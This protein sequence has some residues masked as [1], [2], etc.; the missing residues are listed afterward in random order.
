MKIQQWLHTVQSDTELLR[1]PRH[2]EQSEATPRCCAVVPELPSQPGQCRELGED[3]EGSA[4]LSPAE[5][6]LNVTSVR[7]RD[8]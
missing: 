4:G 5:L 3:G 8:S 7:P 2:L 1:S 6:L